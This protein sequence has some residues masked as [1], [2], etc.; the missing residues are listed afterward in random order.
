LVPVA[1]DGERA[2]LVPEHDQ[3]ATIATV[4]S[5]RCRRWCGRR[6]HGRLVRGEKLL[7]G[8]KGFADSFDVRLQ[9]Q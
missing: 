6:L 8:R 2:K 1:L 9:I 7:D 4:L 5:D 3:A